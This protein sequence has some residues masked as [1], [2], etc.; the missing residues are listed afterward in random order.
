LVRF[1]NQYGIS[2]EETMIKKL[3]AIPLIFLLGVSTVAAP[4]PPTGSVN[5]HVTATLTG[6]GGE[7]FYL[8]L[9]APINTACTVQNRAAI[10]PTLVQYKENVSQAMYALSSGR[11]VTVYF[12]GCF[13]G[14]AAGFVSMVV[15]NHY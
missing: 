12:T 2:N 13:Q 8:E 4:T 5:G 10:A 11:Q 15:S 6:W 9:D 3:F 1:L 14:V 7:A